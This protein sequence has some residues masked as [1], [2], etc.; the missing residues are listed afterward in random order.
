MTIMCENGANGAADDRFT[1]LCILMVALRPLCFRVF[2]TNQ[3]NSIE[4]PYKFHSMIVFAIFEFSDREQQRDVRK[5]VLLTGLRTKKVNK[6]VCVF[7]Q[8]IE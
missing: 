4:L 8:V 5:P 7:S 3:P 1:S 6:F 2:Q